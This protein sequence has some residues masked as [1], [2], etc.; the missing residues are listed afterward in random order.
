MWSVVQSCKIEC[1]LAFEGVIYKKCFSNTA[2]TIQNGK[3]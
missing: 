2:A 3:F 1:K